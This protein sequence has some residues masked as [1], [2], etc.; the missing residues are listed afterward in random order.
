MHVEKK[1]KVNHCWFGCQQNCEVNKCWTRKQCQVL[2]AVNKV[3]S[4]S[5]SLLATNLL[6]SQRHNS[7]SVYYVFFNKTQAALLP[8]S[9]SQN[10]AACNDTGMPTQ[11][12]DGHACVERGK[13]KQQKI[14]GKRCMRNW[15]K[16][17][18]QFMQHLQKKSLPSAHVLRQKWPHFDAHS[19]LILW[20][21]M[22]QNIQMKQGMQQTM[23][24][25]GL[26]HMKPRKKLIFKLQKVEL[27]PNLTANWMPLKPDKAKYNPNRLN[28][29]WM[30]ATH[31]PRWFP[32]KKAPCQSQLWNATLEGRST[33]QW[34]QMKWGAAVP[35]N[36][37]IST[38]PQWG[39]QAQRQGW[40]ICGSPHNKVLGKVGQWGFKWERRKM[41]FCFVFTVLWN[42]DN[43]LMCSTTFSPSSVPYESCKPCQF[44]P[45]ILW[46][47]CQYLLP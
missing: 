23:P 44:S 11:K 12:G 8:I 7:C 17:N 22:T 43:Y 21:K 1:T 9:C 35:S 5:E 6:P 14:K 36:R 16:S 30:E 46:L 34:S 42:Y 27:V 3:C 45:A 32:T 28:W 18:N 24:H 4:C 26:F 40:H 41:V 38:H 37:P 31:L 15:I 10:W 2:N 25:L 13:Y 33:C 19:G 47:L 29:V 20:S 39:W